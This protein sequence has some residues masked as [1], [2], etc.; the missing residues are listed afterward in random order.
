MA[1]PAGNVPPGPA[2]L[3]VETVPARTGTPAGQGPPGHSPRSLLPAGSRAA[4]A[5]SPRQGHGASTCSIPTFPA[6]PF[7]CTAGSGSRVGHDMGWSRCSVLSPLPSPELQVPA[8]A[9]RE[10]SPGLAPRPG[11]A[12]QVPGLWQT[13]R[14][15]GRGA[16]RGGSSASPSSVGW[17][18]GA[19]EPLPREL[20]RGWG[21]RRTRGHDTAQTGPGAGRGPRP[22]QREESLPVPP[23][24]GLPVLPGGWE[25]GPLLLSLSPGLGL[26]PGAASA[27]A[28]GP[29]AV[30]GIAA[31]LSRAHASD[32]Q[33]WMRSI[34][35][36]A[37]CTSWA[38]KL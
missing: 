22:L 15:A 8:P 34:H 31:P 33:L 24:P 12:G 29:A 21:T 23:L 38:Q 35:C 5:T 37:S 25:E 14:G 20:E 3:E 30:P 28:A 4:T 27:P 1:P 10:R 13:C 26:Q 6:F 16:G 7:L 9:G 19:Q 36:W 17:G 32:R 2:S 11:G 18:C